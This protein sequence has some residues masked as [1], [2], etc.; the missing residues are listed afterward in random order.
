MLHVE[1]R[2]GN[3]NIRAYKLGS[4]PYLFGAAGD[5]VDGGHEDIC[6]VPYHTSNPAHIRSAREPGWRIATQ[7]VTESDGNYELAHSSPIALLRTGRRHKELYDHVVK[8]FS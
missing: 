7:M 6:N 8:N 4:G 1:K 5:G 2:R 3:G